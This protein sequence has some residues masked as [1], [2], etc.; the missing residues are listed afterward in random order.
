MD[1]FKPYESLLFAVDLKGVGIV[2]PENG[3]SRFVEYPEAVVWLLY[4]EGHEG[5]DLVSMVSL[6][7]G[8]TDEETE[9]FVS[10]V[11]TELRRDLFD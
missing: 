11:L 7:T 3:R 5:K 9:R 8:E 6:I 1:S 4:H 10:R 2:N